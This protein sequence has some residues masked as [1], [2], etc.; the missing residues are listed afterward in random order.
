[1]IPVSVHGRS[2]ASLFYNIMLLFNINLSNN[3]TRCQINYKYT[4]NFYLHHFKSQCF[5][6]TTL[7]FLLLR[8]LLKTKCDWTEVYNN[9]Y[10]NLNIREQLNSNSAR[11]W[12]NLLSAKYFHNRYLLGKKHKDIMFSPRLKSLY[13]I[14]FQQLNGKVNVERACLTLP[15]VHVQ[16]YQINLKTCKTIGNMLIYQLI[17]IGIR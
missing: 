15:E 8:L 9:Y 10:L 7:N 13:R 4:V 11:H 14:S 3:Y 12:E 16:Y 5:R 2:V 17:G 6:F 1:M